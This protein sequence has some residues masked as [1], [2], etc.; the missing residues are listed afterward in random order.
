MI[1]FKNVNSFASTFNILS[2]TFISS[3]SLKQLLLSLSTNIDSKGFGSILIV[4]C[5]AFNKNI[6]HQV[7]SNRI[8]F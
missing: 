5:N 4:I 6:S 8:T 2:L 7:S 1:V 3:K